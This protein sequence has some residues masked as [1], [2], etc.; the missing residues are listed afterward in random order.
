MRLLEDERKGLLKKEQRQMCF[1]DGDRNQDTWKF[2]ELNIVDNIFLSL[3]E[4]S[5]PASRRNLGLNAS[6]HAE[7][8]LPLNNT[9]ATRKV[10]Q[11]LMVAD[12]QAYELW[13][14]A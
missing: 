14:T 4:E 7:F 10:L 1:D 9:A 2:L 12:R 13:M 8:L 5:R 6:L 11:V 3:Q